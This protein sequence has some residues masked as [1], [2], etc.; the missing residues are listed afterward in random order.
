MGDMQ[1]RP[2]KS[3]TLPTLTTNNICWM[4]WVRIYLI[5]LLVISLPGQALE[6]FLHRDPLLACK[7]Q[8]LQQAMHFLNL[9]ILRQVLFPFACSPLVK[10]GLEVASFDVIREAVNSGH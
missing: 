6:K 4:V 8:H 3:T 1:V 7:L 5:D 10:D 2:L 9:N